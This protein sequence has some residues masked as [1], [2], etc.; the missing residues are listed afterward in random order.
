MWLQQYATI[1]GPYDVLPQYL[2]LQNG[3]GVSWQ[4]AL[5]VQLVPPDVLTANSSVTVT[6]TIAMETELADRTDHDFTFGISDNTS[7]I[8]FIQFDK[9][10]YIDYSPCRRHEGDKLN[11]LLRNR[12]EDNAPLVNSRTLSSETTL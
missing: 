6:I 9:D 1:L 11:R 3:T 5:E 4:Q 12:I 7:Y 2:E 8:G 10:N